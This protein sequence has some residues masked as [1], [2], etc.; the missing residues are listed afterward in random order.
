[1]EKLHEI[2]AESGWEIHSVRET[3][4]GNKHYKKASKEEFVDT[5]NHISEAGTVHELLK[6]YTYEQR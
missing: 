2:L 6:D 5:A 4:G 1:M 3:P